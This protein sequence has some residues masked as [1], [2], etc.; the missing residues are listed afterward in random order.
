M[1]HR[2]IEGMA[3][4]WNPAKYTDTYRRDLLKMVKQRGKRGALESQPVEKAPAAEEPRVLDLVAALER[5]IGKKK[6][7]AAPVGRRSAKARKAL[8]RRSA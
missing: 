1:A 2:L 4:S 7:A 3:T 5:S 8:K 6:G